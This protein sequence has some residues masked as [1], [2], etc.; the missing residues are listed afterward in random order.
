MKT[1]FQHRTRRGGFTLLEVVIVLFI[2]ALVL[3]AVHSIAQGALTLADDVRRAQRRDARQQAFT[4]FGERLF[5]NLPAASALKLRTTQDG[6]QYL[7]Q[8]KLENIPSPFDGSPE[9]L[10]TLFTE[11]RPGGGQRL[12]LSCRKRTEA[13]DVSVVLFDDLLSCEWRA[14]DPATHQWTTVWDVPEHPTLMELSVIQAADSRRWV[15]WITPNEAVT[16]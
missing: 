3:A 4:T 16:L 6:G 7:T 11:P 10:V 5:A 9:C 8:F 14:F 2:V 15:F 13:A 12:L 1:L